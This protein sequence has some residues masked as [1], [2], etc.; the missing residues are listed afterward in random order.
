[1]FDF[2]PYR[3]LNDEMTELAL[4]LEDHLKEC[5]ADDDDHV[6]YFHIRDIEPDIED[7]ATRQIAV[8]LPHMAEGTRSERLTI[9]RWSRT[10][11]TNWRA[12]V[13]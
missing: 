5:L 8:V 1:M 2:E 4:Q 10:N 11:A 3:D 12:E 9:S 7:Y 13:E 6:M